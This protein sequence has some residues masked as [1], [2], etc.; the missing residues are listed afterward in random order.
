[1]KMYGIK[2]V[3]SFFKAIENCEGKVELITE[4]GLYNL[5]SKL[6]QVVACAKAFSNGSTNKEF[7][8]KFSNNAD[9][10]S[11]MQYCVSGY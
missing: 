8:L 2:D 10:F 3:D 1:M 4:N 11:M 7:E 5:K 9:A 6:S